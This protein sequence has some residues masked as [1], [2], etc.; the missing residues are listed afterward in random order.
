[1]QQRVAI[2]RALV[3][4]P[5]LLLMDEPFGALDE[6]TRA[7]MR[8]ELLRIWQARGEAAA[9]TVVFVTHSIPEALLLSD[10]VVVL[11]RQPGRITGIVDVDLPRPRTEGMEYGSEFAAKAHHL[12][13]LL[14]ETSPV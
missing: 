1:M 6:I 7:S 13:G 5:S 14:R 8:F 9:T 12:R 11:S 3:T 10:R 2:A 4:A